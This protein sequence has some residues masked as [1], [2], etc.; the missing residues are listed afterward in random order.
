MRIIVTISRDWD[1]YWTV[2]QAL[3]N[4]ALDFDLNFDD[5]TIVHGA[6]QMDWFVAGIAYT[7]GMKLEAHPA[8]WE[9]DG[10]RAGPMRNQEMVDSGADLCLAFIKN[11]S[12]GATDCA[13]RAERADIETRRYTA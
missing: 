3:A 11:G 8:D 1:D 9:M 10:R 6:S 13:K 12:H 5:I 7:F 4:I 2:Q